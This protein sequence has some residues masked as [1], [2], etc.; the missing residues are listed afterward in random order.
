MFTEGNILL[1]TPF[2]FR[3]GAPAKTKYFIV[4]K[5]INDT[6]VLAS[7]PSSQDYVPAYIDLTNTD[8]C[9]EIIEANFNCYFFPAGNPIATNGWAFSKHTF[10]YGNQLDDFETTTLLDIYP[11]ENID[12]KIIGQLKDDILAQI[13]TCFKNS[14][15]V[16]RKYKRL[17]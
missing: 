5:V 12:Y 2:Y 13:I 4:I 15:T 14:S 16:K 7:L 1:Y 3:N 9:I 6:A 11:I 17:L 10:V 8:C